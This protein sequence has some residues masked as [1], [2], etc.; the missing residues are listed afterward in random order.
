MAQAEDAVRRLTREGWEKQLEAQSEAETGFS[1][2]LNKITPLSASA[3]G[4]DSD[5]RPTKHNLEILGEKIGEISVSGPDNTSKEIK[6]F[7]STIG[8]QLATRVE[9]LRLFEETERG[10]IELERRAR[11]LAAVA[12]VSTASSRELEVETMLKTVVKLTQR[13]FD[14][15]HAHIFTFDSETEKL[16]KS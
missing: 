13:Q 1:Y 3:N 4:G 2:D 7:L 5:V 10:Q 11:Q 9:N 15:Y 12:E 14:L 8:D 6:E 16:N